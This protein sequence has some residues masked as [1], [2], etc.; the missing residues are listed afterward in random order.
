MAKDEWAR[1]R[2]LAHRH[3]DHT[4]RC[5]TVRAILELS[6][7]GASEEQLATLMRQLEEETRRVKERDMAAVVRAFVE[8]E[9]ERAMG[10]QA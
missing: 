1:A 10:G 9:R 7:K 4:R 6:Q 8:Q 3:F 5:V 2:E